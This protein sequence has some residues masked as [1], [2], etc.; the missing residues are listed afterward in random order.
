MGCARQSGLCTTTL[1]VVMAVISIVLFCIYVTSKVPRLETF[2]KQASSL[3]I[4]ISRFNE[5]LDWVPKL[6]P[7]SFLKASSTRVICYNK[8]GPMDAYPFIH[9]VRS[10]PNVGREGHTYLHHIISEYSTLSDL[11]LF[12]PGSV[13]SLAHKRAMFDLLLSRIQSSWGTCIASYQRINADEML[14]AYD[15][16]LA[17][18]ASQDPSNHRLNPETTLQRSTIRPLKR[19]INTYFPHVPNEPPLR[20][21]FTCGII[22]VSK[23]DVHKRPLPFYK[24]LI[25]TVDKHSNPEAGHYL[26]RCW[27]LVFYPLPESSIVTVV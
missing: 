4:V 27:E 10:L 5:P 1:V 9:H 15:F 2:S 3:T 16:E 13:R 25:T 12:L 19:W 17:R 21:G 6:I 26:E 8:G 23:E 11:T 7:S 20:S 24:N 22:A 18:Y 14:K